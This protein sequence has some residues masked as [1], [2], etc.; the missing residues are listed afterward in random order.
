MNINAKR[1]LISEIPK[2]KCAYCLSTENLTYD[3]KV[4]LSKGG[5]NIPKN[6]QVLCR[7]CN[8]YKSRLTNGEIKSLAR[9]IYWINDLRLLKGKKLLGQKK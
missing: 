3:H 4:P 5:K 6:I 1:K 2:K 7:C 9:W 8:S